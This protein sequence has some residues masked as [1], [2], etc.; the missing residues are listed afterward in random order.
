MLCDPCWEI[1]SFWLVIVPGDGVVTAHC[2]GCAAYFNPREM[3]E[4]SPG[5]RYNTYSGTCKTCVK[6]GARDATSGAVVRRLSSRASH[7]V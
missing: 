5:G 7:R 4:A 3:V 1:L 6:E 2:G